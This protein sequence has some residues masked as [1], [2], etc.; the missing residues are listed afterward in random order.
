MKRYYP[1]LIL[2]VLLTAHFLT[3]CGPSIPDEIQKASAHLPDE[4]DFNL[5]IKPL[6]SDR[7]FKCHG[8]DKNNQKA[9]LRLDTPDGAYAALTAEHSNRKANVAILPGDLKGSEVF[10][11]IIS[12]DTSYMMPMPSSN[13]SLSNEDKALIVKWIQQGGVYKKHWSLLAPSAPKP[14]EVKQVA[15]GNNPLDLFILHQLEAKGIR[16]ASPASKEQW[17]RR[18]S[19][20]LTGLPPSPQEINQ[21]LADNTPSA[22]EKVV[23]RLLASPHFGERM[24]VDWLDV[25][26]YADSHGYQD[27]GMRNVFPYRDWVIKA[28][29]QNLPYNQFITWQL[30][31]DMLPKPTRDMLV[32]TCFNRNHPQ[33]QEGGVVDEEYRVEY[34]AD[35]TNTFGKAFLGL[36][37]ECARCHD[38]KYDPISQKDYYQL[39]A[40]FNSN[41]DSG[42]IPYNGEPSPTVILTT[43]EVE[44]KLSFIHNKMM[45]L[46]KAIQPALYQQNFEKW[47]AEAEK[48][49]EKWAGVKTGWIGHFPM[50]AYVLTKDKALLD[51][52]ELSLE[53]KMRDLENKAPNAKLKAW[54]SGDMD[55]KPVLVE[56]KKGKAM[57]LIGDAGMDFTRELEFERNQPFTISL[58]AKFLT[59]KEEGALFGSGNGEF[60]GHRG[61]RCVLNKDQTLSVTFAY[62]YPANCIDIQTLQK[63]PK[64]QWTNITIT[65]DGTSK[66]SGIGLYLNGKRAAVKVLT[67]NLHKSIVYGENHSHW[68]NWTDMSFQIGKFFQGSLKDIVVDDLKAYNRELSVL[69]INELLDLPNTVVNI[70]KT[71]RANRTPVQQEQLLDFYLLNRL[72]KQFNQAFDALTKLRFEES[73]LLTNVPELMT[74]SERKEPRPTFIL[75]RGAYDAPKERV[76][77]QV[78]ASL[79][80]LGN[81]PKNRLGLAQW[82]TDKNHPLTSRVAVNRLWMLCFGRGLVGTQEDFGNQGTLP[83]H[84]ELL[85]YLA[86]D[87]MEHGWDVKR[88]LKQIVL[89][90]TY[91]QSSVSS[92]EVNQKDPNNDWYS[93]YPS[94]RL[95]AEM[96]RDNA[97]TVSGL[98]VNKIG[99][100]SVYPYQPPGIWEALATRNLT[101][102]QQGHGED[103]YRRSLYTVWKRSS[104]PPSMLTF[105]SPDR[106]FCVVRRQKT[107]TP[108]QSLIMMN[109]PQYVEA[110]RKLAE[111]MLTE[112]G[113]ILDSQLSY[114]F[115]WIT[116][117]TPIKAEVQLLN[118]LYQESLTDFQK[119]P[120]KTKGIL[121]VGESP[122]SAKLNRNQLA[123]MSLVAST[124]MNLDEF[125]VKR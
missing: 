47:V 4:V 9:G 86:I 64:N 112:G 107:A 113:Q 7:C 44:E 45:P 110:A 85:D 69:E 91:R 37:L 99:G 19:L 109:D 14:P 61:Y 116:S 23:D 72:D 1:L 26:R 122:V 80:S 68:G 51:N 46:E 10:H 108:L 87:F 74:M 98:L 118:K 77:P 42:I 90:S 54:V 84:P 29:N 27:D 102:Y 33:T 83:S 35:R 114:G 95:S 2:S 93:R 82:L 11:R 24:A 117:R 66:A 32:A 20:D 111:R 48:S 50:D 17:H 52:K 76:F 18:V 38:H 55:R 65:Y 105:D 124:L 57:K 31:G 39:Y 12:T 56:G 16:P 97:L 73:E 58:W 75:A 100:K 121:S 8:P 21:F 34:V 119:N 63:V 6:L 43:P 62:V 28:F 13:L 59:D 36:T 78:P 30:A 120:S 15:W 115:R 125:V 101:T 22:Y 67:D 5:H 60:E 106:Y 123:A 71:P 25:A 103:L 94:Y 40:F 3:S 92:A 89:S 81:Y 104:P 96:I 79:L 53:K 70:L 49:P 88:L 41:N